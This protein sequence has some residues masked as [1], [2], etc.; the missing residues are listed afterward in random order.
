MGGQS[1][2]TSQ[3]Q[4]EVINDQEGETTFKRGISFLRGVPLFIAHFEIAI[5]VA[6][7]RLGIVPFDARFIRVKM[8]EGRD[9]CLDAFLCAIQL[10][11]F[12]IRA[13]FGMRHRNPSQRNHF[14]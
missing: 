10:P 1:H 4:D 14:S 3:I 5:R 8:R 11:D 12:N 2:R 7:G 13:D 9:F 6:G